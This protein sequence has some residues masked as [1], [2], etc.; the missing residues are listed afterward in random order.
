MDFVHSADDYLDNNSDSDPGHH[1]T[2]SSLTAG[3]DIFIP[4]LAHFH[5]PTHLFQHNTGRPLVVS[6]NQTA[7]F[8]FG[9]FVKLELR[10]VVDWLFGESCGW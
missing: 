2:P 8:A 10:G 6:S 3:D 1:D 9:T 4:N 7:L 5:P